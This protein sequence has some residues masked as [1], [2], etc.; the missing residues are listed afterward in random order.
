MEPAAGANIKGDPG[1]DGAPG[2]DG[3]YYTPSVDASGNLTWAAS[4]SGM[5][6]VTG[7]NIR[8]PKGLSL[9]HI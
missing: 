8:G 2:A 6:G 7:A 3:G 9:I 1:S 5:P 4:R